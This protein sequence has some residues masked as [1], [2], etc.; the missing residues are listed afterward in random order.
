MKIRTYGYQT[1][2]CFIATLPTY[3]RLVHLGETLNRLADFGLSIAFSGRASPGP[4]GNYSVYVFI[5][6]LRLQLLNVYSF[7]VLTAIRGILLSLQHYSAVCKL[8]RCY[9]MVKI[10]YI[11]IMKSSASGGLCLPDP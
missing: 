1:L 11:I 9:R 2:E 3:G 7:S 10:L 4:T 6:G 5:V 8:Q